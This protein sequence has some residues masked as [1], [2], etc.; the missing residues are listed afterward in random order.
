MR[1]FGSSGI[2]GIVNE[3][4]DP[5]LS[6]KIGKAIGSLYDSVVIGKDPRPH[7]GM[8]ETALIS[9]VLSQG[10]DVY[11]AG[12]VSTP[13]LAYSTR[14]FDCGI[15]VTASHNTAEYNGV[16]LWNPDGR[17]FDT[18][19]MEHVER[20]IDEPPKPVSW[21][22]VGKIYAHRT[23]I[24]DH[25]DEILNI[26][27]TDHDLKVIVDCANGAGCSITPYILQE[28]GCQVVALNSNPDGRFPAHDPEPIEDNLQDLKNT[29]LD[30][31]ADLGL[32][33]DG[34]AD[35]LV[36]YDKEGR[37]LGGDQ[38]LALFTSQFSE[39]V[40]VPVNSSM[41]IEELAEEVVRTK[42]GDVF[43]A[44][45][46]KEE[47]AQFGGEPSGTW[48][49]PEMSY[50]P[51]AVYAAAFL[52]NLA[53]E[54][55]IS[56]KVE[57]LPEYPRKKGGFHVDGRYKLMKKLKNIYKEDL[58]PERL[59]F[60]DGIRIEYDEGWG[61][62][63]ASGTEPKIRLTA[64]AKDESSLTSIYGDM[65]NKIQEMVR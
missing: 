39:K 56:K 31:G 22:E 53:G 65:K 12:M 47:D 48:I 10:C 44:E 23:S 1:Y 17:S 41:V 52:V 25:K 30:S 15:M 3:K 4:V 14:R 57:E 40:V 34:D 19:Q 64:E 24:E 7:G 26:F 5:D 45:K 16:K 62:I 36:G 54:I 20:L 43:V 2:R 50:A 33:H 35:R 13:T 27:G 18:D 21:D 37:F 49:F 46:I 11:R 58:D 9:G 6:M 8:I 29:V 42:V 59:N 63:R 60:V 55:D 61:L 28:M 38:L 32:A 51:D